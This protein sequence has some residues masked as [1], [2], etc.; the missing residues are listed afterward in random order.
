MRSHQL[1]AVVLTFI[2]FSSGCAALVRWLPGVPGDAP[3]GKGSSVT[4]RV[5]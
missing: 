3:H 2:V 5:R 1:L 4:Q